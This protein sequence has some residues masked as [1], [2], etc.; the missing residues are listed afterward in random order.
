MV[1]ILLGNFARSASLKFQVL[2][3]V[4]L[5]I[6][7]VSSAMEHD[8]RDEKLCAMFISTLWLYGR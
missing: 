6:G 4:S 2:E 1:L 5:K 7:L 8:T 3:I